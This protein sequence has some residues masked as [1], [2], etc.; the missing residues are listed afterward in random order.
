MACGF[1]GTGSRL[2]RTGALGQFVSAVCRKLLVIKGMNL[3]RT[4]WRNTRRSV[5]S[6]NIAVAEIRLPLPIAEGKPPAPI[7]SN[8]SQVNI[9]SWPTG[10]GPKSRSIHHQLRHDGCPRLA[11]G[12]L[13]IIRTNQACGITFELP[14]VLEADCRLSGLS[15]TRP[16]DYSYRKATIGSGSWHGLM[17]FISGHKLD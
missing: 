6:G 15:L 5:L 2:A 17:T 16:L 12:T 9:D 10:L 1:W 4:S 8:L 3:Q 14:A 13:P 11:R 7:G